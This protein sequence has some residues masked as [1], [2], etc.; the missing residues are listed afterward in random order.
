L[1]N[2]RKINGEN[3]IKVNALVKEF[4]SFRA[5]NKISFEVKKEKYLVY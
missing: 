1:F 2:I 5:V 4:N 3:M